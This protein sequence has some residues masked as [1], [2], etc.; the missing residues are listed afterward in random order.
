VL[1][2]GTGKQD[3]A[4][5]GRMVK[6]ALRAG[7]GEYGFIDYRGSMAAAEQVFKILTRADAALAGEH[8]EQAAAIFQAVLENV[9]D[10]IG[11]ADDS[12]GNLGDCIAHALGGLDRIAQ[13]AA[14][15][16]RRA[17]FDYC[18]NEAPQPRYKGWDWQWTLLR[19]A[20]KLIQT[21]VQQE[22]LFAA[23]DRVAAVSTSSSLRGDSFMSDYQLERAAEIKL[24]VI[25]YAGD[26]QA[27]QDF[28][29]AHLHLNK[30]R[31]LQI[32]R[33]LDAEQLELAKRL[34]Q[35]GLVLSEQK[36]QAGLVRKYRSLL[37][38]LAQRERD[39]ANT[40]QL[41]RQLLL[42]RGDHQY[43]DVLRDNVPQ[44]D[45]PAFVEA[46]IRD[47]QKKRYAELAAW[48]YAHEGMWTRLLDLAKPS[49]SHLV[50]PYR[51]ELEARF[52]DDLAVIYERVVYRMLEHTSD[53]S[54]YQTACAYLR[55][56]KA[57]GK[58]E[59]VN[60]VVRTLKDRYRNRR[61]LLEELSRV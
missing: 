34:V 9:V 19:L 11:E 18:I 23:L 8:I 51:A 52:P 47:A 24:S 58:A 57:F 3:K 22:Q 26:R 54:T 29:S 13:V 27:V 20:A 49:W 43:Y 36:Q 17:L 55:R 28:I 6:D 14:S 33:Y 21:P 38:K 59:R 40:I 41:G 12:S 39:T 30:F 61:A 25:E 5:Y 15:S 48:I 42:D 1:R 45:W 35:E 10:R 46:L 32:Q 53:R 60:D 56:M 4:D 16:Q 2:F 50:E 44:A 7:Q 31:M 37:L